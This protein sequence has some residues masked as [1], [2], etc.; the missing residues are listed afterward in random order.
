MSSPQSD[1]VFCGFLHNS[2]K[3]TN[4]LQPE[5]KRKKVVEKKNMQ[6]I[7][8]Q[9]KKN[10]KKRHKEIGERIFLESWKEMFWNLDLDLWNTKFAGNPYNFVYKP[11]IIGLINHPQVYENNGTLDSIHRTYIT[12]IWRFFAKPRWVS[13]HQLNDSVG[14]PCLFRSRFPI[15]PDSAWVVSS[16]IWWSRFPRKLTWG[17]LENPTVEWR[18]R[19]IPEWKIVMFQLVM[20]VF[21]GGR[22]SDIGPCLNTAK[23]RIVKVNKVPFVKMSRLFP[24][25][26][27][28]Q[29]YLQN[30]LE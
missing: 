17:L 3:L 9:R 2:L 13:R 7:K 24:H 11:I 30:H 25:W 16:R 23:S 14:A 19:R 18:W 12:K 1:V 8:S 28:T 15:S 6:S 29:K 22:L 4:F 10:K 21:R 27:H 20:L 26:Y 5:M